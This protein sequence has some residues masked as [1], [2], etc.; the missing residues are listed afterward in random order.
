MEIAN[1][2]IDEKEV[3][4]YYAGAT[5]A[6]YGHQ[7]IEVRQFRVNYPPTAEPMGWASW[8]NAPTNV[9]N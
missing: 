5:T 6:G 9:G 1:I 8:V 2:T 7:K 4:I 3:Q